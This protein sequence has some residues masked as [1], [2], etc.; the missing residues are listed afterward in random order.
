MSTFKEFIM[1]ELQGLGGFGKNYSGHQRQIYGGAPYM[2]TGELGNQWQLMMSPRRR[3]LIDTDEPGQR[4][5]Y[6][7]TLVRTLIADIDTVKII[8]G[9]PDDAYH[10]VYT[11]NELNKVGYPPEEQKKIN[12]LNVFVKKKG[13]D[14]K[15][16][17]DEIGANDTDAIRKFRHG[18]LF[19]PRTHPGF[20]QKTGWFVDMDQLKHIRDE[21]EKWINRQDVIERGLQVFG[22]T[23]GKTFLQQAAQSRFDR[24]H[25]T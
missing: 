13:Y 23:I 4:Y 12:N 11:P 25:V 16:L 3:Q 15:E 14:H 10:V 19:D 24:P 7:I 8:G 9:H 21:L 2:S 6:Y 18:E 5:R 20:T 22:N 1:N 17:V